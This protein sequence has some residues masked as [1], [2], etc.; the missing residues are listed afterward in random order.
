MKKQNIEES[1]IGKKKETTNKNKAQK[2]KIFRVKELGKYFF[3]NSI[4]S[5]TGSKIFK[6]ITNNCI[7]GINDIYETSQ[8]M[9][10][11]II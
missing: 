4:F 7:S 11:Y 2:D 6:I 1:R 10:L 5:S 3:E 9:F 8:K